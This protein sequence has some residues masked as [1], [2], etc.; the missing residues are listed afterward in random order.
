MKLAA[1]LILLV[2]VVAGIEAP[3]SGYAC[4]EFPV[5]WEQFQGKDAYSWKIYSAPSGTDLRT[6]K[7]KY[8]DC[9][10]A[11]PDNKDEMFQ[12]TFVNNNQFEFQRFD[13]VSIGVNCIDCTEPML[14]N[15]FETKITD[16]IQC[17]MYEDTRLDGD[18]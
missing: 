1:L 8:Y 3:P 7:P 18:A 6:I 13:S 17:G 12:R 2:P 10:A 4:A 15:Y 16:Y 5:P 9:R 14:G 11:F